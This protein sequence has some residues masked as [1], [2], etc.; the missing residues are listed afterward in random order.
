MSST[1]SLKALSR[2]D[3]TFSLACNA[4]S[5]RDSYRADTEAGDKM[6]NAEDDC[7]R[8]K[9]LAENGRAATS[10]SGQYKIQAGKKFVL[11]RYCEAEKLTKQQYE[12]LSKRLRGL[13]KRPPALLSTK[14]KQVN[15]RRTKRKTNDK[16]IAAKK[17]GRKSPAL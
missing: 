3:T 6:N 4:H 2:P 16:K 5:K 15:N 7:R 13:S 1:N 14:Q 11:S 8:I 17:V 12:T 10:S 9:E